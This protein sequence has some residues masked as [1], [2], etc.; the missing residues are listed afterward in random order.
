[1]NWP[2]S[3]QQYLDSRSFQMDYMDPTIRTS[4]EVGP[5]KIRRRYTGLLKEIKGTIKLHKDDYVTLENF[6]NV[7][8][9]GGASSF[10]ITDPITATPLTVRFTAP[11]SFRHLGGEYFEVTLGFRSI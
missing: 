5:E 10:T 9:H 7:S 4:N 6:F 1:M 2:T 3:L 8:T 11:P